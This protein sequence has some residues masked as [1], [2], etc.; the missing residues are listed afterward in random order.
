[1]STPVSG[2]HIPHMVRAADGV[3]YVVFT[4]E[5]GPGAAGAAR[6]CKFDGSNWTLLKDLNTGER[7]LTSA[8][9]AC[10]SPAPARA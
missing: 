10:P 3:F 6:L 1:V 8:S 4:K 9:A 7:G 5:S 2:Y